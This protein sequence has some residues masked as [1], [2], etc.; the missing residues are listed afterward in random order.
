M[1]FTDIIHR[2]IMPLGSRTQVSSITYVRSTVLYDYSLAD[3]PLLSAA[4]REFPFVRGTAPFR[5]E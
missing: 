1:S 2:P 3:I 4:S 5:K